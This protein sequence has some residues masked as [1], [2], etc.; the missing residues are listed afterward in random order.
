[1][2]IQV[3]TGKQRVRLK[4]YFCRSNKLRS[5]TTAKYS[6]NLKGGADT[7]NLCPKALKVG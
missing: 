3:A 6:E 5:D 2:L 4:H 1:M 7:R